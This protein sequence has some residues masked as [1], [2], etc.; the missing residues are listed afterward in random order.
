MA[1]EGVPLRYDAKAINRDVPI[2]QVYEKYVGPIT[3]NKM[4]KCP[5]PSHPDKSPSAHLYKGS[6]GN[7]C[8]CFTCNVTFSPVSIVMEQTGLD[9]PKACQQLIDDF[10]LPLEMYSNASQ[11]ENYKKSANKEKFP[12]SADDCELLK[13]PSPFSTAIPNL[14][15]AQE[16]EIFE[17]APEFIHVTPL[18]VIW[19]DDK[20]TTEDMILSKCDERIETYTAIIQ[21]D[22]A[23]FKS[24]FSLIKKESEVV[25][26]EKLKEGD[27]KFNFRKGTVKMTDR[28]RELLG[29]Q[30]KLQSI[31]EEI[32]SLEDKIE[33]IEDIRNRVLEAQKER[34]SKSKSNWNKKQ[35]IGR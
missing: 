11:V 9:F 24:V 20:N 5:S 1:Y 4:V 26:S 15:Y 21:E 2:E 28:Q 29:I 25:E 16:R 18:Y 35:P 12:L 33:G 13:L 32:A 7:N 31:S 30:D 6:C 22:E 19:E 14:N 10:N 17:N 8:R 34:E 3:N 27:E 23:L